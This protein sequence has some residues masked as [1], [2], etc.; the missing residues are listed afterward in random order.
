MAAAAQVQQ[1]D[2]VAG[3]SLTQKVTSPSASRRGLQLDRDIAFPVSPL[4]SRAE[5]GFIHE[6]RHPLQPLT[7]LRLVGLSAKSR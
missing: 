7:S 2:L 1:A 4:G 5:R 6:Y 3:A